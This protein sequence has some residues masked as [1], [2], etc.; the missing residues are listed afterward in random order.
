MRS[1]GDTHRDVKRKNTKWTWHQPE[2][3][4]EALDKGRPGE[5]R[6]S[7]PKFACKGNVSWTRQGAVKAM[8]ASARTEMRANT[9]TSA[10][11][12]I[13]QLLK[14][15]K[16]SHW[17][18]GLGLAPEDNPKRRSRDLGGGTSAAWK[19]LPNLWYSDREHWQSPRKPWNAETENNKARI[20]FLIVLNHRMR[21]EL[22]G[23]RNQ[24]QSHSTAVQSIHQKLM[25][26]SAGAVTVGAR[27]KRWSWWAPL[28]GQW[29]WE[30][31]GRGRAADL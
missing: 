25:S 26:A 24:R 18:L 30:H 15:R 28:Q 17:S 19:P 16:E 7:S 22:K 1:D 3:P 20:S 14:R 2:N 29:R 27:R 13:E 9:L 5:G 4:P 23:K 21:D 6:Q 8:L 12:E 31:G 11:M 10:Y